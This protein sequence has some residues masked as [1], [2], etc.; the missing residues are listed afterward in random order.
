MSAFAAASATPGILRETSLLQTE[1][2]DSG[3]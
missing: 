2:R 1:K 3:E